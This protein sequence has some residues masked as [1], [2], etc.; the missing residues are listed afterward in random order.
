[1]TFQLVFELEGIADLAVQLDSRVSCD[2]QRRSVGRK[3]VVGNG[4]VE[5]V[6]HFRSSHLGCSVVWSFCDRSSSLLSRQRVVNQ[7]GGMESYL[8]FH[9]AQGKLLMRLEH[10]Y[11]IHSGVSNCYVSVVS[12][13]A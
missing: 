2:G 12:L 7:G 6:V 9:V 8:V 1:M 13:Q 11:M 4:V 5:E 3:G 10:W